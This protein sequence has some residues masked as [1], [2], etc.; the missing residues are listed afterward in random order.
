VNSATDVEAAANQAVHIIRRRAGLSQAG[1]PKV[2]GWLPNIFYSHLVLAEYLDQ[3]LPLRWAISPEDPKR[4]AFAMDR[5]QWPGTGPNLRWAFSSSYEV[6]VAFWSFPESGPGAISQTMYNAFQTPGQLQL[7]TRRLDE[8]VYPANKAVYYDRHQR[9][10]GPR[11]GFFMHDEARIP[12][13]TVDGA[14][15]VRRGKDGNPGWQPN[16]PTSPSPSM[17]S[18]GPVAEGQF[19][20]DPPALSPSGQD[21]VPGRYRFTRM[22]LSGRDVDGP[23]VP[24]P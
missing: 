23:E 12:I 15:S 24:Y 21:I 14:V 20:W 7:G 22:G 18:Y 9:H 6:P 11:Q 4:L 10:F 19:G 3:E 5:S 13:A 1:M 16:T 8:V 17:I 2:N